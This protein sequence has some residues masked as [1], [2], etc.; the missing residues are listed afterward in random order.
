MPTVWFAGMDDVTGAWSDVNI[1]T[2]AYE[3]KINNW[4]YVPTPLTIDLVVEYDDQADSGLVRV[5]MFAEGYVGFSDLHL[6]IALTESGIAHSQEIYHQVLRDYIP[7]PNGF[8]FTIEQGQTITHSEPFA[9]DP[10]WSAHNCDIV[11]FVQN[12]AEHMIVQC[13]QAPVPA[14]TPVA[15]ETPP[16]GLPDGYRLSQNYPNPF[17]PDT[18]IRYAIP[19]DE[20]VTVKVYNIAGAEVATLV[21]GPQA[22]GSYAV[23]WNARDRASGV[24][25]CRLEAGEHS[26]MV[27]MVLLK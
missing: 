22:A 19:R 18:E 10:E 17:N 9:I 12:D 6:R 27:K 3:E 25:F 14:A 4:L 5:E 11:A 24:Y 15:T 7:H 1:T 8:A 16:A 23:R 2:S 20:K 26:E 21:G 13:A